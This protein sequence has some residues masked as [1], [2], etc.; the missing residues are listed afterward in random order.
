MTSLAFQ[1]VDVFTKVP[2]MG[3]P[4]A[5]VFGGDALDT[6]RMQVTQ[7]SAR[8]TPSRSMSLLTRNSRN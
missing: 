2:F 5:V 8:P 1:Q 3:N 4:V 7:R 6:E